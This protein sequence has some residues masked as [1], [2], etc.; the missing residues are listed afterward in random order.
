MQVYQLVSDAL[1]DCSVDLFVEEP[2]EFPEM[3]AACIVQL[4][5]C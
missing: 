3:H 2:F 1:A 4:L 5:Q